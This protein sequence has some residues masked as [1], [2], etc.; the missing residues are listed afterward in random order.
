M[1]ITRLF[2]A[3]SQIGC[4]SGSFR[5]GFGGERPLRA[6]R[7]WVGGVGVGEEC[8]SEHLPERDARF[9]MMFRFYAYRG[10]Y[11]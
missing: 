2:D 10:C 8:E 3:V 9:A 11:R 4:I 1:L 7:M 6:E 5:G